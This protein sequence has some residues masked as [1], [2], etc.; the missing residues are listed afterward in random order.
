MRKSSRRGTAG[1]T[2]I[3]A[4]L[5]T[6]LMGI[7]LAAL[8]TI[9]AQWLPNWN[10]GFGR[11][12]RAEQ[13]SLGLERLIADLAA[14]EFV[15]AGRQLPNPVFDGGELA[16]TFVRTA[17]GPNNRPGLEMVRIAETGGAQG[18]MLVR[19]RA[20]F[21]P[22]TANVDEGLVATFRDPVVLVKSPFRVTFSYAGADR[23]WKSSWRG[24]IQL[25][26]AVRVIVRDERTDRTLAAS[27]TT[28]VHVQVP[29]GC[30]AAKAIEE[31]IAQR[32][33]P[34]GAPGA[35]RQL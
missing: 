12:Q 4:L 7:I 35:A 24:A 2:L 5:A 3:E 1:F 30:I 20:P 6:A 28:L 10:R 11:V 31:C 16:V 9:T 34:A 14:A 13:L 17:L 8:A 33:N 15:A 21:V 27:T 29:A 25:P 19:M 23:I 26:R 18:P 22:I 32:A